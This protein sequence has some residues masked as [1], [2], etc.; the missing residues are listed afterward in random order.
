MS[1]LVN[2]AVFMKK[3]PFLDFLCEIML[4]SPCGKRE[5]GRQKNISKADGNDVLRYLDTNSQ[6][7][8]QEVA[9][10]LKQCKGNYWSSLSIDTNSLL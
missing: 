8:R 6:N 4:Q 1:V 2:H 9:F 10:L 7:Y 3:Q 5:Y